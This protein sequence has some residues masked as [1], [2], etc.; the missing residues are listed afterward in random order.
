LKEVN[1]SHYLISAEVTGDQ[2]AKG[3]GSPL[4]LHSSLR[5]G[6]LIVIININM[7]R[8]KKDCCFI[9]IVF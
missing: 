6:N 1:L 4:L 2:T 9:N 7:K 5:L 3:M 8:S